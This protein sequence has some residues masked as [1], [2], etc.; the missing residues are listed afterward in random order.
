MTFGFGLRH[1]I[2]MRNAIFA[3]IALFA[4]GCGASSQSPQAQS[5]S[6][7]HGHITLTNT[8]AAPTPGGVDVSAGYLTI[9]NNS[10]EPDQLIAAS[11][12]RAQRME[13]HSMDMSGGVMRMRALET[14]PIAAGESAELAPGGNHLMFFGVATP[15]AEG[16]NIPV[17]L[18]FTRAGDIDIELPVRRG[19]SH[20]GH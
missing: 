8:W 18:T 19:S 11:S 6:A 12:P 17:R 3:L 7:Q 2:G 9:T 15:F 20:A 14:L 16:E 4:A 13:I 5:Q 10:S 1:C